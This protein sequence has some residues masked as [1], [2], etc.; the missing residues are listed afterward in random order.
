MSQ[1][2]HQREFEKQ[3]PGHPYLPTILPAV[4]RIIA[5]GDVHGDIQL[6][7][8]AFKL[9]KL[10]DEKLN[11]IADPPDTVVVQVGDQIDSCRFF[12]GIYDCHSKETE[13][14]TPDDINV[15][16]FFDKIDKKARE[17]GG[18]VYSLLGNHELLNISGQFN[19][20]SY[21]NLKKFQYKKHRGIKGRKDAFH[22]GGDLARYLACSRLSCLIIGNNLFAH[23]GVL[24]EFLDKL[25]YT[26]MDPQEKLRLLNI[27]VRQWLLGKLDNAAS[28]SLKS[29]LNSEISPLWTRVFGKIEKNLSLGD[30]KCR[31]VDNIL[32]VLKIDQMIIGH[33]PQTSKEGKIS[34]T[35]Y[36]SFKH[37]RLFRV[38]GGFSKAFRL[39][40]NYHLIEVLEI[41]DDHQYRIIKNY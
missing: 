21:N 9:A 28:N 4:K 14:D 1:I 33:T 40:G 34:G 39:F 30:P 22:P 2:N 23:A 11:W 16:E 31:E 10:I 12:Q 17:K 8:S 35:C 3:C 32:Q 27:Y 18:A 13:D 6:T 24:T 20:A 19:Y 25:E 36:D 26:T 41:L 38:D 37:H 7:I 15:L 5:I 29:V